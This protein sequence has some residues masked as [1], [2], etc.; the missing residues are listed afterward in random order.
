MNPEPGEIYAR[1][2]NDMK[3]IWGEMAIFMINKRAKDVNADVGNLTR[4]DLAK[5]IELLR[6]KT[7]PSTLGKEGAEAKAKQYRMWLDDGRQ[8]Q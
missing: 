4:E 6:E 8:S 5:I 3:S 7:L 2:L 1:I